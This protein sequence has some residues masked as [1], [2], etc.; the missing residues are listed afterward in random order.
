[1]VGM[2]LASTN[3]EKTKIVRVKGVDVREGESA[4]ATAVSEHNATHIN[5]G[6]RNNSR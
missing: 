3:K 1:M 6:N 5:T 4:T 2:S